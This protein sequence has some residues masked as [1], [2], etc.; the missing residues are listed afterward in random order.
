MFFGVGPFGIGFGFGNQPPQQPR[1]HFFP[2]GQP[3]PQGQPGA[4][5][6]Q[7]PQQ[8]QGGFFGGLFDNF[9]HPF[10][11]GNQHPNQQAQQ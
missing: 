3:R 4:N 9:M 2:Q 7:M 11:M 5:Q 1:Q 10:F 8:N 6:N